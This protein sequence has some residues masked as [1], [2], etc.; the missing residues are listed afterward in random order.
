MVG[1]II[2]RRLILGFLAAWLI[3]GSVWAWEPLW[4]YQCLG[5]VK[6]ISSSYDGNL[7]GIS[8]DRILVLARDGTIGWSH[9]DYPEIHVSAEGQYVVGSSTREVRFYY[10]DGTTFWSETRYASIKDCSVAKSGN[11]VAFLGDGYLV[12]YNN[13]K[14]TIFKRPVPDGTSVAVSNDGELTA[15]GATN[16]SRHRLEVFKYGG[17]IAWNRT[18]PRPVDSLIVS[19]ESSYIFLVA[20]N[21]VLCFNAS[22]SHLWTQQMGDIVTS[23]AVSRDGSYAAVGSR[24][25]TLSMISREGTIVWSAP[26]GGWITSVD[27]SDNGE[28]VA[29]GSRDRNVYVYNTTGYPMMAYDAS[30][31][32]SSVDLS[33]DGAY[34]MAGTADG[35]VF[36]FNVTPVAV[37]SVPIEPTPSVTPITTSATDPTPLWIKNTKES[38]E[39]LAITSRGDRIAAAGDRTYVLNQNGEQL[40]NGP[41]AHLVKISDDD[42]MVTISSDIGTKQFFING[43][44]NWNSDRCPVTDLVSTPNGGG[45]IVAAAS[46][47]V[48]YNRSGSIIFEFVVPSLGAVAMSPGGETIVVGTLNKIYGMRDDGS[49]FWSYASTGQTSRM[50]FS[51]G[52]N[53]VAANADNTIM[54][55]HPS[56]NLLWSYPTRDTVKD[57]VVSADGSYIYAGGRDGIVYAFNRDGDLLWSFTIGNWITDLGVSDDGTRLMVGSIDKYVYLLD[58]T[59]SLVWKYPAG[60]WVR[61]VG[62]S[63]DGNY[64]VVGTSGGNIIYFNLT[65]GPASGTQPSPS[66]EPGVTT[67]TPQGPLANTTHVI[68]PTHTVAAGDQPTSTPK[69]STMIWTP[70]IPIIVAIPWLRRR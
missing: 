47:L 25:M 43:T 19:P 22:G 61:S 55:L 15:V 46:T 44:L 10:R 42:S 70:I 60:S 65:D 56:G 7:I 45:V 33:G 51:T 13:A 23:L 27:I 31:W 9:G 54:L 21:E 18:V 57:I 58:E 64:G 11:W 17:A 4:S 59:G 1:G 14:Q 52:G 63:G 36:L 26:T 30:S 5:E 34:A 41:P 50:V 28:W 49:I 6:S 67:P 37:A 68:L 39:S 8:S 38:I 20:G 69:A 12:K 66:L 29:A 3:I 53:F 32:I 48:S 40:W 62:V 35:R 2:I 16:G 24:D